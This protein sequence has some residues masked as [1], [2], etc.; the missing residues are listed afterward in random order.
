MALGATSVE[1][2]VL[3]HRELFRRIRA[4]NMANVRFA[5]FVSLIE[6]FG[7]EAERI[8]GSHHIFRHAVS[9]LRLNA[10][11]HHGDA[12]PYQIRQFLRLVERHGLAWKNVDE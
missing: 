2:R 3:D 1:S 7:F 8:S 6:A 11:P 4:G 12:K 5:D 9:P 10:Q